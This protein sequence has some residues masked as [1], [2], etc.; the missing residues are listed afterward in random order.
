[1]GYG[2]IGSNLG[3]MAVYFRNKLRTIQSIAKN[4]QIKCITKKIIFSF[5]FNITA[6]I[7]S[8]NTKL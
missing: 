8:P 6:I 1:M 2:N 7:I 4:F 3:I 5:P